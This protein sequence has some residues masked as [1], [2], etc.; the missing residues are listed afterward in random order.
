MHIEG[1]AMQV[2]HRVVTNAE[3]SLSLDTSDEWIRQRTGIARRHVAAG[4]TTYSLA[5]AVAEQLLATT[6]VAAEALDFII[7]ATMSP[8]YQTPSEANRVQAAIA[9]TNAYALSVNV[10][11]AGFVYALDIAA[12]L[13]AGT[14]TC[15][16]VIGSEV[17]SKLVD[18]RD[19][20]TAVLFGD[21]AGG[22]LVRDDGQ[23]LPPADLHSFGDT[24]LVLAAGAAQGAPYF[25]MNGRAVYQFAIREAAASIARLPAADWYLVHQAN[26]RIIAAIGRKLHLAAAQLPMNLA[27]YGNTSAASIP[28]LLHELAA[29]G[30]IRRGHTMTL[31]GFGGG[32]SVGSLTLTY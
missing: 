21:G 8:D 3:L 29:A 18:W 7:V 15:G 2:P 22:V 5:V 13:L 9:A 6:H 17:L 24:E 19:R 23:P 32:L 12:H 10:A 28:I 31:C 30:R 26:A 14:A 27:E 25:T 11:C 20:S 1:T 4:E 16:L